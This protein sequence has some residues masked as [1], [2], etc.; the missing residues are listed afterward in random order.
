MSVVPRQYP[1]S[2][3]GNFKVDSVGDMMHNNAQDD[4]LESSSHWHQY[5]NHKS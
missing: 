4:K 2:H 3:I 5:G 1:C